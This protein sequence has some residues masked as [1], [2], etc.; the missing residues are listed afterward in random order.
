MLV[1]ACG[2]GMAGQQRGPRGRAMSGCGLHTP[3]D[4]E[5]HVQRAL[6][7]EQQRRWWACPAA[8]RDGC[9]VMHLD[10]V[11]QVGKGKSVL[12]SRR[13][14]CSRWVC[15]PQHNGAKPDVHHGVSQRYERPREMP[16]PT[17]ILGW[18]WGPATDL[19]R[20]CL[21]RQVENITATARVAEEP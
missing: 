20:T 15:L 16:L 13:R 2:Y 5:L 14:S 17:H 19:H 9:F 18:T 11:K 6:P 7:P 12:G 8:A 4:R 10:R 21:Y 1:P 3:I